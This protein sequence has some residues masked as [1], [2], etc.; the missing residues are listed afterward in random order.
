MF[1]IFEFFQE[2]FSLTFVH[3]L[4]F[5]NKFHRMAFELLTKLI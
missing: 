4:I 3:L 1:L 5:D 2:F